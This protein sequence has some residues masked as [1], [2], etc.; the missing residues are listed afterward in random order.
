ME[1]QPQSSHNL[2]RRWL[3]PQI[4]IMW[5]G[6]TILVTVGAI[7]VCF[8]LFYS[9]RYLLKPSTWGIKFGSDKNCTALGI[10]FDEVALQLDSLVNSIETR[11]RG[12]HSALHSINDS[13]LESYMDLL[14]KEGVSAAHHYSTHLYNTTALTSKLSRVNSK[15]KDLAATMND[16]QFRIQM[17]AQGAQVHKRK[18]I[19]L[20]RLVNVY[21]A[22]GAYWKKMNS[23]LVAGCDQLDK[24]IRKAVKFLPEKNV[25]KEKLKS[26]IDMDIV[27]SCIL[28]VA[29]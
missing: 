17:D 19:S 21:A 10:N 14:G 27:Q 24:Y 8:G 20:Q 25:D 9:L 26:A 5:K 4:A 3:K 18:D 1:R 12:I 15:Y 16:L 23:S 7:L 11:G 13:L 28:M 6:K 2:Y 29:D 22:F